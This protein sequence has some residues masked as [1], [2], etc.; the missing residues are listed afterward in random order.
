MSVL[1]LG[2]I[3][4]AGILV[5]S[6]SSV[7]ALALLYRLVAT[8]TDPSTAGRTVG[9]LALFPT[10]LFLYSA[11]TESLFLALTLGAFWC[12]RQG[13]WPLVA[14]LAF[15]TGLTKVQGAFIGLPLAAEYL[16]RANWRPAVVRQRAVEFAAVVLAGGLGT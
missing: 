3:P 4:L 16:A 13:K 8:E 5:G 14:L 11:F 9:H 15:L 1:T 6:L 10:A 2:N 12:A 7:V